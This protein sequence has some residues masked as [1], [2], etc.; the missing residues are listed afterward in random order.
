MCTCIDEEICV[1]GMFAGKKKYMAVLPELHI[2]QHSLYL[3]L[4]QNINV[5][6]EVTEYSKDT[7]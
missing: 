4:L 6:K 1:C 7:P 3:F 5:N 2:K